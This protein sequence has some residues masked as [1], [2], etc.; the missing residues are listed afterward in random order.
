MVRHRIRLPEEVVD[1]P[2]PVSIQ[3]QVGQCCEQYHL[4]KGVPAYGRGVGLDD[5]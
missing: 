3:G 4:V 5:L 2:I 1:V